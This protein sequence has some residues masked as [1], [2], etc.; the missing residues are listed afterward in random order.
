MRAEP[1]G[2]APNLTARA[3]VVSARVPAPIARG[4]SGA[5][6]PPTAVVTAVA[7]TTRISAP[8][9]PGPSGA[10]VVAF[11]VVVQ[12]VRGGIFE[13]AD[14]SYVGHVERGVGS[15][16]LRVNQSSLPVLRPGR[17]SKR[18]GGLRL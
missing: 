7:A 3:V 9:V 15:E 18:L 6:T 2:I 1:V 12:G 10:P 16:M 13:G 14:V 8:S 11:V 5:A 17:S 4:M